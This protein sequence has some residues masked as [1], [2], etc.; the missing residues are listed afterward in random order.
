MLTYHQVEMKSLEPKK[1]WIEQNPVEILSAVR[2]CIEVTL[3]NLTHLDIDPSDIHA[4]GITN[5]R[6]TVIVWDKYTGKPLY[7]AICEC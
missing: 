7:N 3:E 1:G 6:E 2:K 4:I 5:Q